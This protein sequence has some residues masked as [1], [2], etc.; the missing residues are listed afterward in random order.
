MSFSIP[1]SQ[2]KIVLRQ[3]PEARVIS[4]LGQGDS[5]FE[6]VTEKLPSV[7][8]VK[9]GHVLIRVE[10]VSLDPAMRGWLRDARSYIPPVQIG[11]VM[12]AG[13]VGTVVASKFPGLQPGDQVSG[14]LGWQEYAHIPGKACEKRQVAGGSTLLDYL[15]PLGSSGQTAYWGIF[16]VGAIKANDV[17][18]VT[19]AAGSVGSLVVQMA[20]LKGC[21]VIAVAGSDDKCK[22]L[23]ESLKADEA[24]NYK[25][26]DFKKTYREVTQKKYGYIDVVFENV[27]GEVL[28]LTLLCLKPGAR[29]A[30]CGAIADYNNPKPTGL[31]NYQTLIA[32]RAKLQG[33][34]VFDYAKRYH[35]A[36]RD[37][38]KWLA[39]GSLAR[40]FHVIGDGAKSAKEALQ[41]CP[42]ALNDLFDGKN[43]GKMVVK[44]AEPLR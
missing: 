38:S 27:G 43:V 17:V 41:L 15:G 14:T 40:K 24:L 23:K 11:E 44:V 13:G 37:I 1:A 20:K 4:T 8:E 29:I 33:F 2:S 21:K 42:Q 6:Y 30:L 22:W 19:G 39:D 18:V 36:E 32:M 3:R 25:H 26:A 35:E 10:H 5:T 31:K 28:D 7:A 16:D 9:D 12:R 34:I